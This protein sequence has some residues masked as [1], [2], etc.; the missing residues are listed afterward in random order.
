MTGSACWSVQISEGIWLG[1]ALIVVCVASAL[2]NHRTCCKGLGR[3]HAREHGFH[4]L[5]SERMLTGQSIRVLIACPRAVPYFKVKKSELGCLKL[6]SGIKVSRQQ[7]TK[8]I[9]VSV[10]HT[11]VVK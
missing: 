11:L 4:V 2:S 9:V 5:R 6:F 3:V 1:R 8:C 7:V 10:D